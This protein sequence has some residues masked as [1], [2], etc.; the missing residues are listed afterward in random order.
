MFFV[1]L[2]IQKVK[3]IDSSFWT[4]D[5][6]FSYPCSGQLVRGTVPR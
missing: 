1:I 6:G 3:R 5:P 4:G 2:T